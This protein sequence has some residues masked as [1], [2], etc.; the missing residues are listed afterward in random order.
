M[1]SLARL[2]FRA[3]TTLPWVRVILKV[4]LIVNAFPVKTSITSFSTTSILTHYGNRQLLRSRT[5]GEEQWLWCLRAWFLTSLYS[6]QRTSVS[7]RP[8]ENLPLAIDG[9]AQT[10][11]SGRW[12]ENRW[13]RNDQSG[14][15]GSRGSAVITQEVRGRWQCTET[16]DDYSK[17]VV[18]AHWSSC[19]YLLIA[20]VTAPTKS[21]YDQGRPDPS[22]KQG[23]CQEIPP[24]DE[25]LFTTIDN[26]WARDIQWSSVMGAM[27][28][29]PC[30]TRWQHI[31][32][33]LAAISEL[34]TKNNKE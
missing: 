15:P 2:L 9:W 20:A 29:C 11:T 12:T 4:T 24:L 31:H 27:R 32:A 25:E 6:S 22:L 16:V 8:P 30:S 13:L 28:G 34:K 3:V 17:S 1:D 19:L 21:E 23:E 14:F 5:V 10:R 18:L 26:C 7:L 33:H